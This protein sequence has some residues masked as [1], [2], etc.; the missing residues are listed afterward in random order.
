MVILGL[1]PGIA[2]TGYGIIKKDSAALNYIAFGCI[3]TPAG[4]DTPIRLLDIDKNLR[5]IIKKYKPSYAAIEQLFFAKNAKT[6]LLVA[7]ARGAILT[8]LAASGVSVAEYT[9][10]QIKQALT[11]YGRADKIQM[12]KMVQLILKLSKIPEPDDAADALAVA[13]CCAHSLHAS[14][15]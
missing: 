9:P 1:D 4:L 12:Q 3:K 7:H 15:N 13:I 6:A 14:T 2:T 8:V 5:A 10:L 11:G